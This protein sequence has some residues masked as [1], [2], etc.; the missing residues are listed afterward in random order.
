MGKG[1][2]NVKQEQLFMDMCGRKV[3]KGDTFANGGPFQGHDIPPPPFG[4]SQTENQGAKSSL[5]PQGEICPVL[6][7]ILLSRSLPS[8]A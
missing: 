6:W 8:N 1:V 2:R 5:L 3:G 4:F 7:P